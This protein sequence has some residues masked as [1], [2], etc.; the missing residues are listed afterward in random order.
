MNPPIASGVTSRLMP[1]IGMVVKIFSGNTMDIAQPAAPP[2]TSSKNIKPQPTLAESV[3]VS[4]ASDTVSAVSLI[5]SIKE[6]RASPIKQKTVPMTTSKM[7][8]IKSVRKISIMLSIDAMKSTRDA[9]V[10]QD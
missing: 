4:T 6:A 3:A 9:G 7:I 1:V 10:G 8:S 5:F 2:M